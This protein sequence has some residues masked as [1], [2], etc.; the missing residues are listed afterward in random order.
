MKNEKVKTT[1][2]NLKIFGTLFFVLCFLFFA[3]CQ[4]GFVLAGN[5][6]PGGLCCSDAECAGSDI[7]CQACPAGVQRQQ[8]FC[9]RDSKSEIDK[10]TPGICAPAGKE[11]IC[12][13]S[14]YMSLEIL[15]KEVTKYLFWL[16]LAVCPLLIVVGAVYYMFSAGDPGKVKK[17]QA[18]IKWPLIGLAVMLLARM[19][20]EIIK[21]IIVSP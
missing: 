13:F 7:K 17:G 2:K 6:P 4:V 21:T 19:F 5:V 14:I 8:P 18:L 15:V 12:P 20:F 11:F 1:I 10:G 3:F 16:A 9:E